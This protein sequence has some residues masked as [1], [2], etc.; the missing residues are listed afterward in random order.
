MKMDVKLDASW[1]E[2]LKGDHLKQEAGP[3]EKI[4]RLA[5]NI[6]KCSAP[7]SEWLW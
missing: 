2:V 1:K 3:D 7:L 4:P 5:Y 6:L